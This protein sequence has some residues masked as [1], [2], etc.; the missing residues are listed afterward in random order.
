MV[1]YVKFTSTKLI[2]IKVQ[3][4]I[5]ALFKMLSSSIWL[6]AS[7]VDCGVLWQCGNLQKTEALKTIILFWYS[8]Y[9]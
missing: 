3:F 4:L 6:V 5:V 8:K 9:V 2:K 7:V 1:C